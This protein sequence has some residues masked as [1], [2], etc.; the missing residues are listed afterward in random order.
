MDT[1]YQQYGKNINDT[2]LS[3]MADSNL[4]PIPLNK[5]LDFILQNQ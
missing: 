5:A 2:I 1:I 3:L 4:D